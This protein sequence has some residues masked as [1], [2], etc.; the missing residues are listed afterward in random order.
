MEV[1]V[2]DIDADVVM[3]ADVALVGQPSSPVSF[4]TLS[5]RKAPTLAASLVA[6]VMLMSWPA[7]WP[8]S[9][10]SAPLPIA[11]STMF[12]SLYS[13]LF[14]SPAALCSTLAS[15]SSQLTKL[16]STAL[17]TRASA[18]HAEAL[19]VHFVVVGPRR[20][21]MANERLCYPQMQKVSS[22]RGRG[23]SPEA[24]SN[25][26]PAVV[27]AARCAQRPERLA[28]GFG[29]KRHNCPSCA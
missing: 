27:P 18:V 24:G 9:L 22:N 5:K 23:P 19:Q 11:P 13:S 3:L 17:S 16:T 12:A 2:V 14:A 20:R 10:I 8:R 15:P 6:M 29:R 25:A 1:T 26:Q 28:V 4:S 21:N 7:A